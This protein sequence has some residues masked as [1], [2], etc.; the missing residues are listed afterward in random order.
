MSPHGPFG[1]TDKA[2]LD[3]LPGE[4]TFLLEEISEK[5]KK[6]NGAANSLDDPKGLPTC[7]G[8]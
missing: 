5:D 7:L 3:N 6:I 1:V 4:V 2:G 8:C